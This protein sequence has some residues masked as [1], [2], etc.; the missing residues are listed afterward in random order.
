MNED[1]I[2]VDEVRQSEPIENVSPQGQPSRTHRI[3]V[4]DDQPLLRQ[5]NMKRLAA[6]GYQVDGAEDGIAAWST[7]RQT[8][9]DLIITDNTMPRMTGLELIEKIRSAGLPVAVM[10]AS[11]TVPTE[12]FNRYPWLQP[13]AMLP[14]PYSAVEFLETVKKVL[15]TAPPV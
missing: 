4:V 1:P 10:M 15:G 6:A 14:K 2:K 7:L 13:N 8:N 3:L 9:Y 5:I 11:G 12:Q